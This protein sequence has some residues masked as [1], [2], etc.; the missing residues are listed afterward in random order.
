MILVGAE[1]INDKANTAARQ[2]DPRQT[3]IK[4][5]LDNHLST[6]DIINAGNEMN[7]RCTSDKAYKVLLAAWCNKF[8]VPYNPQSFA[9]HITRFHYMD[10]TIDRS[11]EAIEEDIAKRLKDYYDA[12]KA[13]EEAYEALPWHQKVNWVMVFYCFFAIGGLL[14]LLFGS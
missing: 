11:N 4:E 8:D 6:N 10:S 14:S 5:V 3:I 7:P 2:P 12:K 9:T 13:A 1:T